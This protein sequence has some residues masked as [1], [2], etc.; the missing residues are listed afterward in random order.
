MKTFLLRL[1]TDAAGIDSA[2][3]DMALSGVLQHARL[4]DGQIT[5]I[6]VLG[7]HPDAPTDGDPFDAGAYQEQLARV[8]ADLD[9]DPAVLDSAFQAWIAH[10]GPL[11]DSLTPVMNAACYVLYRATKLIT[12]LRALEALVERRAPTTV[13]AADRVVLDASRERAVL[14]VLRTLTDRGFDDAMRGP[15][16]DL[17]LGLQK[18][19]MLRALEADEGSA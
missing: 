6:R 8:S 19:A 9:L 13:D 2:R 4:V 11:D 7:E 18:R 5:S 16:R 17:H 15:L 12:A 14:G 1:Q 3:L 10:P